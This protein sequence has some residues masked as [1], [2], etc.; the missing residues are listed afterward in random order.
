MG[1]TWFSLQLG[2][3]LSIP[4]RYHVLSTRQAK[5]SPLISC[6]EGWE[7]RPHQ[8]GQMR[9]KGDVTQLRD[10]QGTVT[11]ELPHRLQVSIAERYHVGPGPGDV[12]RGFHLPSR[13]CQSS[14]PHPLNTH[15]PSSHHPPSFS[16]ISNL[17]PLLPISQP[18]FHN[19]PPSSPIFLLHH[20]CSSSPLPPPPPRRPR[21][22]P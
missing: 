5:G 16:L 20:P 2:P 9:P 11:P 1:G 19:F 13:L 6:G 14:I 7:N 22:Q 3:Q 21:P 10:K 17:H 8:G 18:N 12:L 15:P 4:T